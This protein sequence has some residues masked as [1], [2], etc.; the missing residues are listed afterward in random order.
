MNYFEHTVQIKRTQQDG[1]EKTV[2]EKLLVRDLT[3]DLAL[4]KA[5]AMY[6][7]QGE[8]DSIGCNLTKIA[9]TIG[10]PAEHIF[11]AKVQMII[12]DEKTQKE[13]K[14]NILYAVWADTFDE[15][16]Q[17]VSDVMNLNMTEHRIV[18]IKET[19]Y[20]DIIS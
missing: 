3:L 11:E 10:E 7:G 2:S 8:F 17:R 4:N 20:L 1:T 12:L 5:E 9:E 16:K 19:K 13:K 15:A 14:T 6:Q 18:S